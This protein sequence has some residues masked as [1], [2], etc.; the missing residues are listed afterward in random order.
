MLDILK[1]FF[2]LFVLVA[3]F[4]LNLMGMG[5]YAY[6]TVNADKYNLLYLMVAMWATYACYSISSTLHGI[7]VEAKKVVDGQPKQ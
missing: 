2:L 7:Y 5:Y 6:L 1:G 3:M 4:V